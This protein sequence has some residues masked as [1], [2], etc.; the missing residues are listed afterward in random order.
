MK[1]N[2]ATWERWPRVVLGSAVIVAGA[3]FLLGGD[4]F[5]YRAVALALAALGLDFVV[6][7]AIGFCPLY[8][9]LGRHG[10]PHRAEP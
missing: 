1:K 10:T 7:G 6:T 4:T 8:Y 2:L 9:Q 3:A 5:M